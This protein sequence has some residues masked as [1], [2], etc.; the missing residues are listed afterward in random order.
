MQAA[1][2]VANEL[3]GLAEPHKQRAFD[4]PRLALGRGAVG[5]ATGAA[6]AYV[7]ALGRFVGSVHARQQ[8]A[9][10]EAS[11][12]WAVGEAWPA[13]L[14][15]SG[16][17]VAREDEP[18][19]WSLVPSEVDEGL[20]V[21]A[22]VRD[23]GLRCHALLL[24]LACGEP[25]RITVEVRG[26]EGRAAA[27]RGAAGRSNSAWEPVA[28]ADLTGA[29][30]WLGFLALDEDPRALEGVRVTVPGAADIYDLALVRFG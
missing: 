13:E 20:R 8:L 27:G 23:D 15:V 4:L 6:T 16:G 18:A 19:R 22:P 10:L 14:G 28:A 26:A 7:P 29:G 5:R 12:D 2:V 1:A 11:V 30:T 25:I 3:A 21:E 24:S 9:W 17:T